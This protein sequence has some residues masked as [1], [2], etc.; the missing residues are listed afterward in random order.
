MVYRLAADLVV[1][2]HLAFIVFVAVGGLVAWRWPRLVWIHLPAAIYALLIVTVG[3]T[4][5]LTP[6]EKSLRRRAGD[7]AYAEGFVDHYL[8]DVVYP[9]QLTSLLRGVVAACVVV[10]YAGLL[11]Q[12]GNHL[13]HQHHDRRDAGEP[14]DGRADVATIEPV[15]GGARHRE[16]HDHRWHERQPQP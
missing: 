14:Q 3:F 1:I 8:K 2:V 15:A 11:L 12:R 6:L 7:E 13:A 9:G 5:P 16:P 4:C 10:G